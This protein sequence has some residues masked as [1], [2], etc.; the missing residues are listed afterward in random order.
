MD[1]DPEKENWEGKCPGKVEEGWLSEGCGSS[2]WE[3]IRQDEV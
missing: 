1:S 2:N 3:Q